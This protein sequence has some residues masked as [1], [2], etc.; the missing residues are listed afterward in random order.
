MYAVS[1]VFQRFQPCWNHSKAFHAIQCQ[2]VG[3]IIDIWGILGHYLVFYYES[4]WGSSV[5]AL[6]VCCATYGG[7]GNIASSLYDRLYWTPAAVVQTACKRQRR[8]CF[9]LAVYFKTKR[10]KFHTGHW[11]A[12]NLQCTL[13]FS[14]HSLPGL[15]L[16]FV[17]LSR[18]ITHYRVFIRRLYANGYVSFMPKFWSADS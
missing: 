2:N 10:K 17:A 3:Y 12:M 1:Y 6:V 5:K 13:K 15:L 14:K 11:T 4:N 18:F 7:S 8:R 16:E 9:W